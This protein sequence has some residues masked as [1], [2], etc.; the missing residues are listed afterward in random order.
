MLS[1]NYAVASV[2]SLANIFWIFFSELMHYSANFNIEYTYYNNG[3]WIYLFINS[4]RIE[5]I[6]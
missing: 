1:S 6:E 3:I 2:D 4:F 5:S